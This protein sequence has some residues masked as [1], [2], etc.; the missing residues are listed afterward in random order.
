MNSQA[1]R[2]MGLTRQFLALR[3]ISALRFPAHHAERDGFW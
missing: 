2:V 1:L 3:K